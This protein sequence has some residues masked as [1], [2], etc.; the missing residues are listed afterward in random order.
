[1][2]TELVQLRSFYVHPGFVLLALGDG[3]EPR[4]CVALRALP[5]DVG[6][7]RRLFVKPDARG[8]GSGRALMLELLQRGVEHGF[9]RLV[10]NTLPTMAEAVALYE[11]L[12]FVPCDPYVAEAT[13]GVLYFELDLSARLHDRSTGTS[14]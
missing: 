9:G 3:D 12:G 5:H 4:G 10:L 7:V 13:A 11:T 2:S 1:M 14:R 6:E 8:E